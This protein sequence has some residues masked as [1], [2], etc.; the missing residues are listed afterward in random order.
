MPRW[1]DAD[2]E[3]WDDAAE[4][5]PAADDDTVPCPH[6]RRA[7]HEESERCPHCERYLSIEDAPPRRR[8]WW[9]VAG[10][11]ASLYV[12]YRWITWN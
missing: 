12:V 6:C 3:A 1:D 2:D 10:F 5:S 4:D 11:L 7:I 9:F 8:P